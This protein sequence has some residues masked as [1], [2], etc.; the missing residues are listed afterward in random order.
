MKTYTIHENACGKVL[1]QSSAVGFGVVDNAG[2]VIELIA[3]NGGVLIVGDGWGIAADLLRDLVRS[4]LAPPGQLDL[5]EP[6]KPCYQ[7]DRLVAWLA[8]DSRCSQCTRMTPDAD[9]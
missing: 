7:C 6:L 4:R 1:N 8:P 9:Q 3:R 5:L 2:G